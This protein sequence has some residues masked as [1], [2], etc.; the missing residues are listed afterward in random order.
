M[1]NYYEKISV[2]IDVTTD[3][4][5]K[6]FDNFKTAVK[7]AEG[8]QGKFKAGVGSLKESLGGLV[9]GP[10]GMAAA[11]SAIAAAGAF[12][13]DSA[14][15]FIELARTTENLAT[16]TGLTN[17][18]AS[19][20]IE[21]FGDLGG[22][23]ASLQSALSKIPKTLD[24]GKWEE[25]GVATRNAGGELRSTNEVL[26]DGLQALR[27]IKDP[28]ARAK[29]GIDL[30]G[31]SWGTL[32]PLINKSDD[33]LKEALAT[34]SEAKVLDDKKIASAKKL[35]AAQ[36]ALADA[37]DDFALSVGAAV[38]ELA[39]MIEDL[40]EIVDLGNQIAGIEVF[41]SSL[42]KW[43]QRIFNPIPEI[44]GG[45]KDFVVQATATGKAADTATGEMDDFG[46]ANKYAAEQ[47]Y[48]AAQEAA[49]LERNLGNKRGGVAFAAAE[50]EAKITRLLDAISDDRQWIAVQ[51]AMDD[52]K[53]RLA[54]LTKQYEDGEIDQREYWL[55]TRDEILATKGDL[56]GYLDELDDL[57]PYLK[58][59]ILFEFDQ[60]DIDSVLKIMQDYLDG[61]K[62]QMQVGA[63]SVLG[64]P[65]VG[66][67][68]PKDEP[69]Q[70]GVVVNVNMGVVGDP[71]ETGRTI[72][73]LIQDYN[74]ATGGWGGAGRI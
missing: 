32:A 4:A 38:T 39:P 61:K 70:P 35:A 5:V 24:S 14:Q 52:L 59:R 49:E 56:V 43:G 30:F 42:F 62:V 68:G 41:G 29:A 34:V 47:A 69:Y 44:V 15:K 65:W 23:A 9:T 19:R 13:F 48:Y 37:F 20:L 3:K 45:L 36:D 11:G 12:A 27:A 46:D 7:N 55:R 72:V 33:E 10:A 71:I 64:M 54:D 66:G 1:A 2:L 67:T 16:A 17:E 50:A 73:R 74:N 58:Q 57:D 40:A 31:K 25:Y 53:D 22:D 60:G 51:L 8:L 63:T 26:L 21:V 18:E 6:G 28:T